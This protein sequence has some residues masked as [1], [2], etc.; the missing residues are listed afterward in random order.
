MVRSFAATPIPADVLRRV[1]RAGLR[2]P[3]AGNTQGTDLVVLQGPDQT[4]RYWD[5]TLTPDRRPTFPWP[6]LLRAP[7]LVIPFASREAYLER[8]R[9]PD[10]ARSGL[11]ADADRWPVPYWFV[12]TAFAAM[13]IQLAAVDADLGAL[14]FG[15]FDHQDALLAALDVPDG[16]EPI[17]TIALGYPDTAGDRLSQSAARPRRTLDQVVHLDGW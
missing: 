7:V 2:A 14:F 9:E 15:I 4:A 17:G 5:V 3:S 8:Y 12:D 13:L 1:L 16:F 6:G 10:K 11:G